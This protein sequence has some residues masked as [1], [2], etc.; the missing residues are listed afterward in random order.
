VNA[1]VESA[2]VLKKIEPP[3]KKPAAAART[4]PWSGWRK[5]VRFTGAG[6]GV[7]GAALW[8]TGHFCAEHYN[9]L[10][11]PGVLLTTAEKYR[12]SRD[13]WVTARNIGLGICGAGAAAFA[14]TFVF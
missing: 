11:K 12:K 13:S 6:I 14:I 7:A 4:T 2:A 1:A 10:I 9:G 3:A 5:T 8:L